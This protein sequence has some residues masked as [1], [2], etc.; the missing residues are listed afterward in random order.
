MDHQKLVEL[1]SALQT[2]QQTLERAR[3]FAVACGKG[4]Y[5]PHV[6]N[7]LLKFSSFPAGNNFRGDGFKGRTGLRF[8]CFAH[9][10]HQ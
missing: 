6:E 1:I 7:R 5:I 10:V 3:A 4:L 8:Q 9:A 2:S